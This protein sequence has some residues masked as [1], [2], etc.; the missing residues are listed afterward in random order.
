MYSSVSGNVGIGAA[1]PTEKLDV[2]GTVNM[3]GFK[4]NTGSSAGY[5]LTS[6]GSGVGT[7]QEAPGGEID[8][9]GTANYIP[10]FTSSTTLGNSIVYEAGAGIGIQT[11]APTH[12]LDVNGN[13]RIRNLP[14]GGGNTVVADGS[15]A[16][17]RSV[18]SRRY[19]ENIRVLG[20][21]PDKVFQ[22]TPVRFNWKTMDLEDVG[23]I[24]EDV[25]QVI[26]DLVTYDNEG[27]PD[28]V[29]YDRLA[30]YLLEVVKAQQERI[31]ALEKEVAELTE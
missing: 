29:K 11:P 21:D 27:R 12:T 24:A 19:K 28:G 2:A 13:A 30:I 31:S 25:H 3:T 6:D 1:P 23:L 26:P 16:L 22:L 9:S 7:W 8:G 15:G 5:D 10:K 18:S 17:W 14:P 4:M 20:V